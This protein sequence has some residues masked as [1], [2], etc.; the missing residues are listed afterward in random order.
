MNHGCLTPFGDQAIYVLAAM[1][2]DQI[3]PSHVAAI[4][5]CTDLMQA[6]HQSTLPSHLRRKLNAER[7]RLE[8]LIVVLHDAQ[9]KNHRAGRKLR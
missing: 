5:A 9:S 6:L 3:S 2:L 7:V 8:N 1:L 4:R